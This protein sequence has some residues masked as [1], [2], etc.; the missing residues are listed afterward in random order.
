VREAKVVG[1]QKIIGITKD[2]NVS[3]VVLA[4]GDEKAVELW[5]V[6]TLYLVGNGPRITVIRDNP[7]TSPYP[8][9]SAGFFGIENVKPADE[10]PEAT[11]FSGTRN[12]LLP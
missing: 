1:G 6:E 2:G 9:A 8:Y 5:R 3:R 4:K 7:H 10:Q 11:V 12:R